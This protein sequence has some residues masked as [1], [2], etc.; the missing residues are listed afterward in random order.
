MSHNVSD[1]RR[2][3]FHWIIGSSPIMTAG[4]RAAQ[5]NAVW[6]KKGKRV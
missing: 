4:K 2:W 3:V 1:Y 5:H 6:R